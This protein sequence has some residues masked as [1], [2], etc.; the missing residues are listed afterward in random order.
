M[1]MFVIKFVYILTMKMFNK[2]QLY[3]III[4]NISLLEMWKFWWFLIKFIYLA[5]M[6]KNNVLITLIY[7]LRVIDSNVLVD[8][9]VLYLLFNHG[10]VLWGKILNSRVKLIIYINIVYNI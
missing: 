1:E 4:P 2:S 9:L 10:D 3:G 5:V 8:I 6:F 7:R